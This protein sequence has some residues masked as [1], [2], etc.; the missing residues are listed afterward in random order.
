MSIIKRDLIDSIRSPKVWRNPSQLKAGRA[1]RAAS[2]V[3]K[4]STPKATGDRVFLRV[5]I[6]AML[7]VSIIA[8]KTFLFAI[9][10]TEI[11]RGQG[12]G[13]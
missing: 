1:H 11:L 5:S 7:M 8:Q 13:F 3:N 10:C 4:V 12:T 2:K 6:A 9:K